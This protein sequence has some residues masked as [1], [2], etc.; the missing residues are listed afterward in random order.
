MAD[1]IFERLYPE[2]FRDTSE[3]MSPRMSENIMSAIS[4]A[5]AEKR[6]H[7]WKK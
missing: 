7:L 6:G 2:S 5:N 1:A 4:R 3:G